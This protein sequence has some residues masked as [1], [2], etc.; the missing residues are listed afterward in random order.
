MADPDDKTKKPVVR[1]KKTK[2][3]EAPCFNCTRATKPE[4]NALKALYEGTATEHQ[5]RLAL[6]VIVHKFSRAQN[7]LYLPND[8]EGTA[9]INGRGF[10]GM[11]ILNIINVP[12]G[13]LPL[14]EEADKNE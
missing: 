14:L 10:V 2:D 9:F 11:K 3:Q 13:H 12:I 5:Q 1:R 6:S 7:L 4:A 8:P